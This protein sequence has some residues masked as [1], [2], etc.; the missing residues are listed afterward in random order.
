MENY[1]SFHVKRKKYYKE[2]YLSSKFCGLEDWD[3]W[4]WETGRLHN[5]WW[6]SNIFPSSLV[7]FPL[8]YMTFWIRKALNKQ[9]S[10]KIYFSVS[11]CVYTCKYIYLPCTLEESV[12]FNTLIVNVKQIQMNKL[13]VTSGNFY[14]I[15]NIVF[16]LFSCFQIIYLNSYQLPI[17]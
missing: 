1:Y 6:S 16:L 9:K 13:K 17:T 3:S 4:N 11:I 15:W 2:V 10:S 14:I 5:Y 8:D 7:L 12:C